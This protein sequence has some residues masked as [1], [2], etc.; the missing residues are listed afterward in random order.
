MTPATQAERISI[1][2]QKAQTESAPPEEIAKRIRADLGLTRAEAVAI[3]R[4]N[5][6][7][8]AR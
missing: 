8:Q 1:I 4:E 6:S 5:A 7:R 3:L 2:V